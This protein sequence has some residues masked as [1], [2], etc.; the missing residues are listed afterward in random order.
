MLF[1]SSSDFRRDEGAIHVAVRSFENA[2][3]QYT[4]DKLN[5]GSVVCCVT[6]L[7]LQEMLFHV[8]TI[9]FN[10]IFACLFLAN[11]GYALVVL[12]SRGCVT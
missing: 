9:L 8:F 12:V 4:A 7:P 6:G 1:Y 3:V 10:S 2:K 5:S 11:K